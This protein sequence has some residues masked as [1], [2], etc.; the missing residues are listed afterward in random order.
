MTKEI[1]AFDPARRTSAQAIAD[2]AALGY[3]NK[4]QYILDATYGKG[5]FWRPPPRGWQPGAGLIVTND[6]DRNTYAAFHQDYRNLPAEWTERYD[7]V[8]FDPPF[9]LNGTGGSHASDEAYGVATPYRAIN[10]RVK[11]ICQGFEECVRVTKPG[12][13]IIYKTQDQVCGGKKRWLS[14]IWPS[15][16]VLVDELYIVGCRAQPKGRPQRHA[17]SNVSVLQIYRK[18]K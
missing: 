14:K 18:T 2:L 13:Q 15:G 6:L 9:K 7:V 5:R 11:E 1:M 12:G 10:K 16:V 3:L 4:D 8:V 17:R